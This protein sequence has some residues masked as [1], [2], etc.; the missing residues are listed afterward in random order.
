[1]KLTIKIPF[2]GKNKEKV[3]EEITIEN[4]EKLR[5]F[6][7]K[8]R[9]EG[10]V[11]EYYEELR[12]RYKTFLDE[13]EEV[14]KILDELERMGEK[15]FTKFVKDNLNGVRPVDKET[16]AGFHEFYTNS[17]GI[18]DRIIKIPP[19][20]QYDVLNYEN[21]KYVID[22]LNDFI[23]KF[24]EFKKFLAKR[25]GEYTIV[26]DLEKSLEK[27]KEVEELKEKLKDLENSDDLEKEREVLKQSLEERDW[28][29]VE[30]KDG[31]ILEEE[32]VSLNKEIEE[33]NSNLK[34][35][36]LKAKRP[37]SKIL[38]SKKDNK[39]FKF[40]ENFSSKPLDTLDEN[41]WKI[42]DVVKQNLISLGGKD[43]SILIW[44]TDFGAEDL[45]KEPEL[46]YEEKKMLDED[47][48]WDQELDILKEK[49]KKIG[50]AKHGKSKA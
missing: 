15:K 17:F 12:T 8:L 30:T 46:E 48:D 27:M 36:I 25:Y 44:E 13:F 29:I 23:K 9:K 41:F 47:E 32:I 39:L 38:Y 19:P 42:V 18:I 50:S 20:I 26:N 43:R 10:K 33:I 21:G 4:S 34:T 5:E 16:I 37:I 24:D 11:A 31:K 35:G 2:F 14:K 40:F 49:Q 1:M 22:K 45:K 7:E 6:T 3:K 28:N